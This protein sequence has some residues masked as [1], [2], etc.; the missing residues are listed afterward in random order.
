MARRVEQ[1]NKITDVIIKKETQC[2]NDK[3]DENDENI[4]VVEVNDY[5]YEMTQN[6]NSYLSDHFMERSMTK[7][8]NDIISNVKKDEAEKNEN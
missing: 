2:A 5:Q 4:V 6:L 7:I 8:M 1:M 3:R